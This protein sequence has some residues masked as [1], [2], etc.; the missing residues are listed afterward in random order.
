MGGPVGGIQQVQTAYTDGSTHGNKLEFTYGD[1]GRTGRLLG[2]EPW[3]IVG[4]AAS[5]AA[6]YQLGFNDGW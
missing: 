2:S 5:V 6:S 1:L 3:L 4:E